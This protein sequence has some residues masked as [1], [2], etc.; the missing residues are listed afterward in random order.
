MSNYNSDHSSCGSTSPPDEEYNNNNNDINGENVSYASTN[1]E[2]LPSTSADTSSE[3]QRPK[4]L[5]SEK[6]KDAKK[7]GP[8]GLKLTIT[9]SFLDL[10]NRILSETDESFISEDRLLKNANFS[11]LSLTIGSWTNAPTAVSGKGKEKMV[12]TQTFYSED[13]YDDEA[14]LIMPLVSPPSGGGLGKIVGDF[15]CAPPILPSAPFKV[16]CVSDLID[17]NQ[18]LALGSSKNVNDAGLFSNAADDNTFCLE[19]Q[20]V[21]LQNEFNFLIENSFQS[22]HSDNNSIIQQ[23]GRMGVDANN[24]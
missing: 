21:S 8:L 2:L 17:E 1:S 11:A 13:S 24:P 16:F 23:I 15:D 19:D 3:I 12:V 6:I 18:Y 20:D 22:M 4:S 9:P 7:D 10:C 14:A 5:T